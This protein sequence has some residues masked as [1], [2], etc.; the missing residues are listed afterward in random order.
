MAAAFEFR[1]NLICSS[2]EWSKLARA[3]KGEKQN[4]SE[5]GNIIYPVGGMVPVIVKGEGC[6]ALAKIIS[7]TIDKHGTTTTIELTTLSQADADA[8]FKA[9][10]FSVSGAGSDEYGTDAV[11]P[12]LGRLPG[13]SGKTSGKHVDPFDD[14]DDDLGFKPIGRRR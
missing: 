12:G 6:K 7:M 11:V 5:S 9:Y 13:L 1:G 3:S 8:F 4:Y 14:D 10:K 2:S